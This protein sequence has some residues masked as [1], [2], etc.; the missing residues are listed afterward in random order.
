MDKT[1]LAFGLTLTSQLD[2]SAY[3][4]PETTIE[5]P[6]IEIRLTDAIADPR[7][8]EQVN[9]S[10][11]ANS[12]TIKFSVLGIADY[13]IE[14]GCRVTVVPNSAAERRCVSHFLVF[15]A[16]PYCLLQRGYTVLSGSALSVDNGATA[17]L[18]LGTT[19]TG[20]STLLAKWLQAGRGQLISDQIIVL[21]LTEQGVA[22]LPG[23]PLVKLWQ[24]TTKQLGIATEA[25]QP[26]R[27]GLQRYLWSDVPKLRQ[28]LPIRSLVSIEC[29]NVAD[30]PLYQQLKGRKKTKRLENSLFEKNLAARFS[31]PHQ[32]AKLLFQLTHQ[33]E[34]FQIHRV[35]SMT[36]LDDIFT[37][38]APEQVDSRKSA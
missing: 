26:I 19:G 24:D 22:A 31:D 25:L 28:A 38:L 5:T 21:T 34:A 8:L 15:N 16:L 23:L 13:F 18:L 27:N 37:V 11:W 7:D 35:S 2:L 10:L 14:E 4:F 36:T 3:T 17:Q 20:K 32:Q 30:K 12:T 6:D 1:Y 9:L 29:S 33:L